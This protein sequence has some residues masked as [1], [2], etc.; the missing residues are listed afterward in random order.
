MQGR[1]SKRGSRESA[2]KCLICRGS[3]IGIKSGKNT[4]Q[5]NHNQSVGGSNPSIATNTRANI[6]N[7]SSLKIDFCSNS[8]PISQKNLLTFVEQTMADIRKR[9]PYQWQVR[10]RKKGYPSQTRTFDTKAEAEV[11]A[12]TVESEM[13][14]GI[15]VSRKEAENTTLSEAIDRYIAEVIPTKKQHHREKN[16]AIALQPI[17]STSP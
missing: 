12:T 10:I 5:E 9:G 6:R 15:F 8:A 11:W 7:N 13:A 14:R 17:F 4:S 1:R 2:G 3:S 16:R